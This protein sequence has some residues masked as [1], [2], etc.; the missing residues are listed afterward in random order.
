M[1]LYKHFLFFLISINLSF[2]NS[3]QDRYD[4][5]A[6][7][8][9]KNAQAD[10]TAYKRLEY[11]CDTY[12]PRLSGSKNLERSIEWILKKMKLDGLENVKGQRVKVPTWVRGNESATLIKPFKRNLSMLGL[13]GSI[14]T[15]KK[16]ITSEVIVVN[17]F[18]EL[19]I[20]EKEVKGKI[21]LFNVPFST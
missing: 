15:S 3:I 14:A 7:R 2:S 21:V 19:K 12:G 5:V 4:A 18:D 9:I 8:I 16:G 1:T 11:L 17:D 6:T 20:K 13:G 10:S